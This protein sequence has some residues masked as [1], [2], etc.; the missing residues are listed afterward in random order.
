MPGQWGQQPGQPGQGQW[1]QQQPGQGQWGQQP[2]PYGSGPYGGPPPQP[3]R[4]EGNP[5]LGIVAGVVA[6]LV[7]AGLYGF[8]VK[9]LEIQS[10]Y[11]GLGVAALIAFAIGKIGGSHPALPI[12]AVLLALVGVML[13]QLTAITLDGADELNMSVLDVLSE[14]SSEIFKAW[15]EDLGFVDILV[16]AF[17]GF[18][19]FG[20]TKSVGEK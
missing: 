10:T 19:A 2:G 15:K 16:Y 17:A 6:M 8:I 1:G 7:A 12:V 18:G 5:G 14:Y 13:G 9:S 20:I 4:R 11:F 3:P